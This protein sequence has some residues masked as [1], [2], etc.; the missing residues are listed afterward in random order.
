MKKTNI[1][2]L[3]LLCVSVG[4]WFRS[5]SEIPTPLPPRGDMG[6][7][8]IIAR[9]KNELNQER[10]TALVNEY[11]LNELKDI[12]A[13]ELLEIKKE[14]VK[15]RRL[16]SLDRVEIH[17]T[18]TIKTILK[19]TFIH[20]RTDTVGGDTV[21]I[22]RRFDYY[23]NWLRL[24]G[25]AIGDSLTCNYWL[26]NKFTITHEKGRKAL[27]KQYPTLIHI[28]NENPHSMT[29]AINTYQIKPEKRRGF[30]HPVFAFAV[31]VG[32]GVVG[33]VLLTR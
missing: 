20:V 7:D 23:D 19:D 3:V 13:G 15:L 24:E 11:T 17:T 1:I 5:C 16:V 30:E 27:F 8:S 4:Y 9:L 14:V 31:G 32:V 26:K 25:V 33:G 12:N 29:T 28:T 21:I 22:A 10:V 2:I 18:D 6:K